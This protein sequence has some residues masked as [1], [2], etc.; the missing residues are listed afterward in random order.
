METKINAYVNTEIDSKGILR[1]VKALKDYA[2]S[3]INIVDYLE[4]ADL[5][6]LHINGRQDRYTKRSKHI[7]RI[8]KKYA[9]IQYCLKSTMRPSV[10]GW[11]SIWE[12]AELVWSYYNLKRICKEEGV[13]TNF[14]FYYAPLGSDRNVFK[15]LNLKKKY[16]ACTSGLSYLSESVREVIIAVEKLGRRVAHLGPKLD[17]R[18]SVD[19]FTNISDR[20]VAKLYNQ[21]YFV[22]GLRRKE[23]F[24]LPALEGLFCGVR[25]ILFNLSCYQWYRPWGIFIPELNRSGVINKLVGVLKNKTKPLN[26]KEMETIYNRFNYGKII[27]EFWRQVWIHYNT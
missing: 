6:V 19:Y 15:P 16:L 22:S 5:V 18:K 27:R 25:P 23:G 11:L 12:G 24:E 10:Q 9:V 26:Q 14:N 21:C 17:N 3:T 7:K 20:E 13:R 2:P 1:V 8:G 4:S